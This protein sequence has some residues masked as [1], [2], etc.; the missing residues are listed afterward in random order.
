MASNQ[1]PP[2]YKK[3]REE[4]IEHLKN[5][6]VDAAYKVIRNILDYPGPKDNEI[7]WKDAFKLFE[8][9]V[10]EISG[11]ELRDLVR[12]IVENPNDVKNLYDLAYKLYEQ[13][14][15]GIAATLL[16]RAN[17]VEPENFDIVTELAV[18]LEVLMFNDEACKVLSE[19]T[20]LLNNNDFCRYLVAFNS[21]MTGNLDEPY[22]MLPSIEYSDDNEVKAM[23]LRLKGML[24]RAAILKKNRP[25]DN[26]DL[27]GWHMVLN[28][29]FLLH[30]S[31]FGL[32]EGMNGRYAYISDSFTLC[33]QGIN[34]VKEVLK[35]ASIVVPE[36]F[37]LP[38]RSSQILATATS[39]I[40]ECPLEDWKEENMT[41]P[42][43]IVAYDLD[44]IDSADI[45]KQIAEHR[46]G[47]IL[48][49]HASCWTNPFP[50]S[51]DITTYLYQ[52][53]ASPWSGGRMVF[54]KKSKNV[55]YDTPDDSSEKEI[56]EK[57]IHAE[58]EDDY[59]DDLDDLLSIIKTLK[60]LKGED[61]PGIFKTTGKRIHQRIGSPV[62]SNRF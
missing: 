2:D 4:I 55:K 10:L 43:L 41:K 59:L 23:G 6:D 38:D 24:N 8:K 48:W 14:A 16:N 19:A 31:P 42:G 11:R 40:F 30:I 53:S 5:S 39:L 44:S 49:A 45:L 58:K 22:Q 51:P 18:N 61:K 15:H 13:G 32:E 33:Q 26:M 25:L 7:I 54:D 34:R 35:K 46:S 17:Y 36:I 9:I 12:L 50:F 21:L 27:R 56:A 47:Q 57:I 3:T 37:A 60:E 29:S 20:T 62:P 52:H 1:F 28:G